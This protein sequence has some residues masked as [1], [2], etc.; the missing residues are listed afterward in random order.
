VHQTAGAR[1]DTDVRIATCCLVLAA[2]W[3]W[4]AMSWALVP[5]GI[6]VGFLLALVTSIAVQLLVLRFAK[7]GTPG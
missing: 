7:R 5:A 1:R 4:L 2:S 3:G 6:A